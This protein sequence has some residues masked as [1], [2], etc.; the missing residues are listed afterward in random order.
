[1]DGN[2]YWISMLM[3]LPIFAACGGE[4]LTL[5]SEGEPAKIE[6]KAGNG[7]DGPVKSML[8]PLVVRVT[9]TQGRPVESVT[10]EFVLQE[11]GGGG[12]VTPSGVTDPAG[13]TRAS[14]TL[15]TR[16]GPLIGEARVPVE[17]GAV[18]LAAPFQVMATSAD[19]NGLLP[20]SGEGQKGSVGSTLPAPLVVR[21]TDDF[22]NPI[23]GVAVE[24]TVTGGGSVSQPTTESNDLGE[25]S[26]QRVLGSTAGQQT[27]V[28]TA[29]AL[30]GASVTFIHTA[31]AGSAARV[32]IVSGNG[33]QA[34]P[35]T[36]LPQPLV[37]EVLDAENNP[38]VGSAVAWVV[39][40]GDGSANPE[41]SNTDGQ[42]RATTQWTLGAAPGR[43]TLSAVVSGVGIGQFNAT[44]NRTASSTAITSHQPEP[45]V[46]GQAVEVR[47]TVNGSGGP[48]SG[49][50]NVT[51]EGANS[52]TITLADG[53][54]ACSLTFSSE[55][56]QRITATYSGD[57]RFNGSSDEENHRVESENSAPTAAFDPPSC[58]VGQPCQFDDRSSDSDGD[59][60]AWTWDF[61]DTDTSNEQ[62]PSHIYDEPGTYDVKLTVRDDEGATNEVTHQ[63]SVGA[64]ANSPPNAVAD[65]YATP[66]GQTLEVPAPGVLGNDSDAEGSTLSARLVSPPAGI[67]SLQSDGSFTYFP[68]S[69]ASGTQDTFTYEA[70]DG[71]STA[72]ATVTITIQ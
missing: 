17:E 51:A 66:V 3:S 71:T 72:T 47:V 37:V 63:V 24:W 25:T 9:D 46:I 45:S 26:V 40:T 61:G 38:I 33:Q 15:G 34:P 65:Q 31:T 43:N 42:G 56:Q 68:G 64:A 39:G 19:A 14:I 55:G 48:P 29:P 59:V 28:A 23:P 50:V 12:T 35:G 60:V 53:S 52:C 22:D 10:V 69:A 27:T 7:Q 62:N 11:D 8:Q 70:S 67:V 20:V 18:P 6:I 2:R 21:V 16:V 57:A 41:T 5:P 30:A 13:E 44:G 49:T 54:G 32:I 4:D 36:T 58:T 1:V